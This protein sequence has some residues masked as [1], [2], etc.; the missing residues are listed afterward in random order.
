MT[1]LSFCV[2]NFRIGNGFWS[3]AGV[4]TVND[5]GTGLVVCKSQHL[6]SF[7]VLVDTTGVTSVSR[8]IILYRSVVSSFELF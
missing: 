3:N 7:A 5:E 1:T 6:T 2:S 4:D 8:Y